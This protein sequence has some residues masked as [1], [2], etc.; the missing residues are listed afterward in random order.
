MNRIYVILIAGLLILQ[1]CGGVKRVEKK[2]QLTTNPAKQQLFVNEK[3]DPY[4][5]QVNYTLN[6]PEGYVPSCARLV[7]APAFEA[8]GHEYALTPVVITGKNYNRLDERQQFFR[9]KQP[10]YPGAMHFVSGGENMQINMNQVVPFELWMPESKLV[11]KV[12][13]EACDR[14]TLLYNQ[15]LADGMLYIPQTPGP[16]LVQYVKKEVEKKEEGFARFRY[17]VNGYI[18]DPALYNN[19]QEINDMIGLIQKIVDDTLAT[20]NRIVIT[21]ICS[22]DGAWVF[23]ENLAKKRAENVKNYLVQN[24]KIEN[25]LL[26]VKYIAE[27]WEGLQKL[28]E[29]SD[30]SDKQAA[31]NIINQISEPD[32]REAAL[33]RLPQFNYIKQQFYPQLRKVSYEI[34]YTVKE[35]VIEAEPE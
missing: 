25:S 5:I 21:G 23:N 29:E 9:D 8:P 24:E 2:P 31:L 11:A 14:E 3:T 26:E 12:M 35:T 13:L 4:T 18:L 15:T 34:Y 16:A 17:A 20:V 22:P 10:D 1:A 6:V 33:R 32:Q 19:R 7:Y 30:L 28:I 27:D